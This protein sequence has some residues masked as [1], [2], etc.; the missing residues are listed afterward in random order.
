MEFYQEFHERE[1]RLKEEK[2]K[3]TSKDT[4][5]FE[6]G[7]LFFRYFEDIILRFKKKRE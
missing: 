5:S 1:K 2:K 4:P 3:K 6:N 7:G